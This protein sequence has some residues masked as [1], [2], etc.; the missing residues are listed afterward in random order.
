MRQNKR[1]VRVVARCVAIVGALALVW[2]CATTESWDDD[3]GIIVSAASPGTQT[4]SG[5]AN[6]V[7]AT[8]TGKYDTHGK[9]ICMPSNKL[10]LQQS[11]DYKHPAWK[12]DLGEPGSNK[13]CWAYPSGAD[14]VIENCAN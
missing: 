6:K 14:L 8:A 12:I 1:V 10:Q 13:C 4:I 11:S 9:G 7:S 3:L 2:A 5:G